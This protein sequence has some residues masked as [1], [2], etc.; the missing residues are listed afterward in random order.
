MLEQKIQKNYIFMRNQLKK[1]LISIIILFSYNNCFGQKYTDK[2][3]KDA[4]I[5]ANKWLNDM[6][7][8]RF[9]L[10]YSMMDK[11]VKEIYDS[12]A[13]QGYFNDLVK[14]FGKKEQSR[15]ILSSEFLSSVE[16]VGDGFF[17]EIKYE[18]F[19]EKTRNFE[20]TILLKQNDQSQWKVI[21]YQPLWDSM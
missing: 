9:D 20:E 19:F 2:Y 7:N 14:E 4:T 6:D 13:W 17:V 10:T 3:I 5:I 15:K 16:G 1:I 21:G 8:F 12:L 11:Q 18:A